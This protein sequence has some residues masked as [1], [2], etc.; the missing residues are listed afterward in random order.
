MIKA[1]RIKPTLT[2]PFTRRKSVPL[3]AV[4][5]QQRYQHHVWR[6]VC[7]RLGNTV[8][9][10]DVTAEVFTAAFERI[11]RCPAPAD[12]LDAEDDPA[13]AWIMAIARNKVVDILRRRQRRPETPLTPETPMPS[14]DSL[15][16]GALSA[17]GAGIL[18]ALLDT[19]PKLQREVLLLKYV[20][21]M[22]LLEIAHILG[23]SPNA[24]GQLLHRARA[25]MREKGQ[26]YFGDADRE[27]EETH[28]A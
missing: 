23:K 14:V 4:Y 6:Y 20:D 16:V 11:L 25:T 7:A 13:R 17:E 26:G 1:M 5:L 9:A 19:L 15:E 8:E 2:L 24:V 3:T 21:E 22:S 27:I 28:H 12:T 10:E 18:Y